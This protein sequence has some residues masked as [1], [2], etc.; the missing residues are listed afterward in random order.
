MQYC[1][2]C[3]QMIQSVTT[4]RTLWT[5]A[6]ETTICTHCEQKFEKQKIHENGVTSLYTYNE[7]MK[8]FVHQLKFGQDVALAQV[9]RQAIYEQLACESALIVPIPMHEENKR[10]RTFAH[11]DELLRAAHIPFRHVLKKRSTEMMAQKSKEERLQVSQLF[12]VIGPVHG[13]DICLVDDIITTGTTIRLA[14][15]ALERAG[16]YNVKAFTLIHG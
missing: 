15:E 6:F 8:Q 3:E 13:L 16:A 7:A 14:K 4:W 9:F 5:N 11:V 10:K 2:L 12:D 1:L